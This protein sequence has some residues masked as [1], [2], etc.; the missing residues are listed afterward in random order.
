MGRVLMRL[1][2]SSRNRSTLPPFPREFDPA[3]DTVRGSVGNNSRA[4][5]FIMLEKCVPPAFIRR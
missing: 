1:C 5:I 4:K 2:G 3:R